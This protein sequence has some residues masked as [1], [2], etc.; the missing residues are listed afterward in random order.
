MRR[1][2][3]QRVQYKR[4]DFEWKQSHE[5]ETTVSRF[6][7]ELYW[8]HFAV[9]LPKFFSIYLY[10]RG[11]WGLGQA[12]NFIWNSQVFQYAYV[13]T[14]NISTRH[15]ARLT[16]LRPLRD[17]LS[18]HFSVG[19]SWKRE[20]IGIFIHHVEYDVNERLGPHFSCAQPN[21]NLWAKNQS[22]E[23][24]ATGTIRRF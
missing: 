20:V 1:R 24:T 10:I 18:C 4:D 13:C 15:C 17:S 22:V 21:V 12:I 9:S 5:R 6:G 7:Q 19:I 16:L 14:V 3:G 23:A 8:K 11:V 2:F